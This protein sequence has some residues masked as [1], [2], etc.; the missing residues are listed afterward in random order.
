MKQLERN[1][2]MPH[3]SIGKI[4][5]AILTAGVMLAASEV[6]AGYI[7]SANVIGSDIGFGQIQ[8]QTGNN[9]ND[10]V[11]FGRA[12][13]GDPYLAS[14]GSNPILKGIQ[15]DGVT[16]DNNDYTATTYSWTGGTPTPAG[17]WTTES[18]QFLS[19][20]FTWASMTITSPASSYEAAFIVHNYYMQSDLQVYDNNSLIAT[21]NNVM[22][23]SYLTGGGEG[24][25][26]DYFYDFNLNG[27]TT[28]DALTFKFTNLQNLGSQWA[29][30][31]IMSAS[32]N[33][34]VPDS[35]KNN[36]L[37]LNGSGNVAAVPEPSAF[38]LSG[39]GGLVLVGFT[40]RKKN[41]TA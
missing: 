11:L 30:I 36:F 20:G 18:A 19:S 22:S 34:V 1:A 23:S 2:N 9:V 31:G 21:Y 39:I 32:V 3:C 24:R 33:Y 25:N 29:N 10:F 6:K 16:H 28:G 26:T 41:R 7:T 17:T 15:G 14:P 27:L 37:T 40:W 12:S 8:Y 38:A 13:A 4:L 35:I 5:T